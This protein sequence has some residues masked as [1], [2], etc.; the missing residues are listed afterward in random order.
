MLATGMISDCIVITEFAEVPKSVTVE[1]GIEPAVFKCRHM[2]VDAIIGWRVN[3]FSV[4]QF[5]NISRG[6]INEDG[7]IVN[8]LIIPARSEYNGSEVVCVGLFFGESRAVMTNPA[9][10]TIIGKSQ[11]SL[12]A[13]VCMEPPTESR[14]SC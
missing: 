6:L 10:L 11:L 13:N 8:T 7:N 2:S 14:S 9:T 3:N 12:L 4:G 1:I 5:P